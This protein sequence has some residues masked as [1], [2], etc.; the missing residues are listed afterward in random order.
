[1]KR[2]VPSHQGQVTLW[3]SPPWVEMTWPVPRQAVQRPRSS[4]LPLGV[5]PPTL[6]EARRRDRARGGPLVATRTDDRIRRAVGR[7]RAA[8]RRRDLAVGQRALEA[9][10]GE[11]AL[12]EE[13]VGDAKEQAVDGRD[14]ERRAGGEGGDELGLEGARD[15]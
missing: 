8:Q 15:G 2:P 1:M 4:S 11:G 10:A 14:A 3:R 7:E 13:R 9:E 6:A 12:G 5:T